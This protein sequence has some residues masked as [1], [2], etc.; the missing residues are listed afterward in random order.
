MCVEAGT[1]EN[2]R[3]VSLF[4]VLSPVVAQTETWSF[5]SE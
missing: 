5:S 4:M 2:H 3:W 1:D